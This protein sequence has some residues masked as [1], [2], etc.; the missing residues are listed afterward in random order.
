[1]RDLRPADDLVRGL[2]QPRRRRRVDLVLGRLRGH[3]AERARR[4]S[5]AALRRGAVHSSTSTSPTS[6]ASG[7]PCR[8]CA[9]SGRS[10]CAARAGP[11]RASAPS[12]A[13]E[14]SAEAGRR[15]VERGAPAGRSARR[16]TAVPFELPEELAIDTDVA[17]RVIAEFIRGQ[18]RQAG[19]ERAVLGLSGGI[20]SALVAYLVAEAIG[21]ERLLCVLLPYRTSSPASRADAEAVV[22]RLGCAQPSWS[23]S[24]RWSMATSDGRSPDG[25]GRAP[26]GAA[27]SWP[28]C[29]WPCCTTAR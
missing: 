17:R 10:S 22:R 18:L 21:A 13:G 7:S 6:G 29:G 12:G 4:S 28:G 25:G 14:P 19:F 8:C 20:D 16:A 2:L 1:M 15:A 23:T 3:R 24:A 26:S 5:G 27:T 9:T 11:D